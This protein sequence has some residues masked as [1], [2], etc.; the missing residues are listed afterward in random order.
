MSEKPKTCNE[1]YITGYWIKKC[2]ECKYLQ[3]PCGG[4]NHFYDEDE[5]YDQF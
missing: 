3:Y 2:N 4:C 1:C 5:E